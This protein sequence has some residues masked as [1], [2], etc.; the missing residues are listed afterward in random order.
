MP[1]VLTKEVKCDIMR[2]SMMNGIIAG[3]PRFPKRHKRNRMA[4]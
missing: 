4:M 1:V 2:R 3:K